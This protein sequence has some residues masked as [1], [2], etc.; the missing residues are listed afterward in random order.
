MLVGFVSLQMLAQQYWDVL[1]KPG[2]VAALVA[3][4]HH[5]SPDL[6]TTLLIISIVVP[7]SV[8]ALIL[9]VLLVRYLNSRRV[10]NHVSLLGKVLPPGLGLQTTLVV[11]DIQVRWPQWHVPCRR[12][13]LSLSHT[14]T[15]TYTCLW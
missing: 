12:W 8:I 9:L 4:P 13:F 3:K 2:N 7:V 14:H 5:A 10:R 6:P 1:N 15:H 11:T